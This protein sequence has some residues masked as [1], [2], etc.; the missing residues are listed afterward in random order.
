M[1]VSVWVVIIAMILTMVFGF[2]ANRCWGCMRE[3][4]A[5]LL[6]LKALFTVA[7]HDFAS[8][9]ED[10]KSDCCDGWEGVICGP[11]RRVFSLSFPG[12]DPN[13]VW[14]KTTLRVHFNAS[15]LLPLHDL[16]HL[17]LSANRIVTWTEAEG[18]S[19]RINILVLQAL[20][21]ICTHF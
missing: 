14:A 19:S 1:R 4:K 6:H 12:N 7:K 13:Y 20:A 5:S 3:E 9:T 17:D 10:A 8:W 15:V 18:N 16:R 21:S 11:N 2:Q